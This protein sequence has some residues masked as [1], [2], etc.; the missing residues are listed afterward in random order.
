MGF[1]EQFPVWAERQRSNIR[2]NLDVSL[3][4]LIAD[5]TD[6]ARESFHSKDKDLAMLGTSYGKGKG[7]SNSQYDPGDKGIFNHLRHT[8]E[9]CFEDLRNKEARTTRVKRN[10]SKSEYLKGGTSDDDQ[11]ST[12]AGVVINAK[13]SSLQNDSTIL[14]SS[15][16]SI[17][18]SSVDSARW[19]FDTGADR[20]IC[21]DLDFF[22]T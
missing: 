10:K 13:N 2:T 1:K 15:F 21:K 17:L 11:P 20:H 16:D 18:N 5:I 7:L 8:T 14:T 6:E 19:I 22:D 9:K 3:A 4:T 12:F